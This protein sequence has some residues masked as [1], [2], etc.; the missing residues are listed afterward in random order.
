MQSR[1]EYETS[2][3]FSMVRVSSA[4]VV[5]EDRNWSVTG[6]HTEGY[7]YYQMRQFVYLVYILYT[8]LGNMY[9]HKEHTPGWMHGEEPFDR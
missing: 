2:G 8:T 6:T 1:I 5:D 7:V 9:R 4:G 3:L